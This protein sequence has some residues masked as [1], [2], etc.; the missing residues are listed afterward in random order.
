MSVK[1]YDP[2]DTSLVVTGTSLSAIISGFAPG[3]FIKVERDDEA[4]KKVTG[5]DGDTSRTK[6]GNKSGSVSVTLKQTSN[7]NA[8]FGAFAALDEASST[9]TF[10]CT[11]RDNLGNTVFAAEAWVRKRPD[12]EYSDEETNR[13][14][15]LDTGPMQQQYP[16]VAETA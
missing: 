4:F 15:V 9:G 12:M 2:G 5:P 3:T 14:W 11:L 10:T 7:S 1:T 13:E 16:V 6:S 8:V